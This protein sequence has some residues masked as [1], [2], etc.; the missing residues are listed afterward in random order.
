MKPL[1]ITGEGLVRLNV[2]SF[3]QDT[4]PD[5]GKSRNQIHPFLIHK[6]TSTPAP[7][8]QKT[9]IIKTEHQLKHFITCFTRFS[10]TQGNAFYC[11]PLCI[12]E[13]KTLQQSLQLRLYLHN[14]VGDYLS[15]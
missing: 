7:T 13:V 12:F 1:R 8:Q 14:T 2:L 4:D 9:S 10:V 5:W 6:L 15:D 11:S 3:T